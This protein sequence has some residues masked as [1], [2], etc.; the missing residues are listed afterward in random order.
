MMKWLR[1]HTKQIMVVVVLLAMFSFVGGSALYNLLAVDRGSI[2][3]M[4]VFGQEVKQAQLADADSATRVLDSILV[5]W[6]YSGTDDFT[7]HHWFML[8]EEAQRAGIVVA[9]E[10]I[11]DYLDRT[12][13]YLQARQLPPLSNLRRSADITRP[14]LREALRRH[15]RIAKHAGR[16]SDAAIPSEPQMRHY[17]RDT[18]DKMRVRFVPLDAAKFVD[19]EEALTETELQRY[20]DQYK[21]TDAGTGSTG[22]GYKYADRVRIQYAIASV[23]TLR[24]EVQV[25]QEDVKNHWKANKDKYKKTVQVDAPPPATAP[26]TTRPTPKKVPKQVVKAFSESREDVERELRDGKALKIARR[27]MGKLADEM[28]KPWTELSTDSET[29]FKPIPNGADEADLLKAASARIARRFGITIDYAELPLSS[30]IELGETVA[31]RNTSTPSGEGDE[32][33]SLSEYAFRVKGLFSPKK[34][35]DVALRLQMFQCPITPITRRGRDVP[36]FAGGQFR[37]RPGPVNAYV[38]FRVVGTSPSQP[39]ATL[40]EVRSKVEKDVR[41]AHAFANLATLA[42]EFGAV[43]ARVGIEKALT[44]FE[45][46]R[47]TGG[48][49]RVSWPAAF[50]R[51]TRLSGESLR[52]ALLGGEATLRPTTV[53]GVGE[54]EAFIDACFEMTAADWTPPPIDAPPSDRITA[55]TTQPAVDPAPSVRLIPIERMRKWF[56]VERDTSSA[57]GSVNTASYEATLRSKAFGSLAGERRAVL[58]NK[59]FDPKQIETRCGFEDVLREPAPDTRGGVKAPVPESDIPKF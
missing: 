16:V 31:L 43:A 59:W 34:G 15:M 27:A 49:S 35:R 8:G 33:L 29:G 9:D 53:S 51:K 37:T 4:K 25:T 11:E 50:S 56:I 14:M 48:V 32:P 46:I 13:Q 44:M 40:D 12:D 5:N 10:D 57:V 36:D 23:D 52:D 41:S 45:D 6:R 1:A 54:S 39:P 47:T 7:V 18:E 22:I 3:A 19:R 28:A 21:D 55:A 26:T 30:E 2:V 17:V 24:S 58:Q 20:F 42:K 38:L